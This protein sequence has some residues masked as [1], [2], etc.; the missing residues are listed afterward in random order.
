M[1]P[2][3]RGR[4]GLR[5]GDRL[6]RLQRRLFAPV[7]IS[8]IVVFRFFFGVILLWEVRRYFMYGWID[9]YWVEPVVHFKYYGFTWLEPWPGTWMHWHMIALGVLSVFIALGIFYRASA[10]LF[11]LGFTYIFLLEQ[12]RYLN[13]FYLVSL[14]SWIMVFI[15]AHRMSSFDAWLRPKLASEFAPTWALWLLRAQIGIAYFF[16]GVAKLNADWL[17]GAP[18]RVLMSERADFERLGPILNTEAALWT[19]TYGGLL[20]DLSVVPLLLWRRTRIPAFILAVCFHLMNHTIFTIGIFPW[21][22]MAATLLY[23]DPDWPRGRIFAALPAGTTPESAGYRPASQHIQKTATLVLMTYMVFQLT[24]PL[25]HYLY[26]GDVNWTE[27]GHRFSWHM[28]LRRKVATATFVVSDPDTGETWMVDPDV[29]LQEWHW[30]KM[31]NTPDMVLQFAKFLADEKR[32]EGHAR[33]EVRAHINASLNGRLP[34]PLIRPDVDLAAEPRN[35]LPAS[36]IAPL[37]TPLPD[38]HVLW[39]RDAWE[40]ASEGAS[41]DEPDGGQ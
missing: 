38:S 3:F 1:N 12:G 35:L 11:A 33:V 14:L 34:Q 27:E 31:A 4:K 29:Q 2:A 41:G 18:A 13:H 7:D 6:S 21:F 19:I 23:F 16:G 8:S 30:R 10:V 20:L 5:V 32:K 9:R 28:I 22:M 39:R 24:F 26:P 37:E 36:W 15:P 25:R 17:S 40:D